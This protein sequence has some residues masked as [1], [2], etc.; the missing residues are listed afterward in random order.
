MKLTPE[1]IA[2]EATMGEVERLPT[3]VLGN[4]SLAYGRILGRCM[5]VGWR[6]PDTPSLESEVQK[7]LLEVINAVRDERD[8]E[9]LATVKLVFGWYEGVDESQLDELLT[10][11]GYEPDGAGGWRKV[12]SD[13]AP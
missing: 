9:W 10:Q 12:K 8:R 11:M 7:D 6:L 1:R 4:G 3:K 13:Q 2:G 5:A